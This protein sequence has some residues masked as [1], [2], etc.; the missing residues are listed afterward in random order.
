MVSVEII[1]SH[2]SWSSKCDNHYYNRPS[3]ILKCAGFLPLYLTSLQLL[4]GDL[5]SVEI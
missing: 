5:F 3:K 2:P 4:T 1:H